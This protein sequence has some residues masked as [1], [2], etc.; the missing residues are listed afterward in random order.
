MRVGKLSFY[1]FPQ[2]YY[3][4]ATFTSTRQSRRL[5]GTCQRTKINS[6]YDVSDVFWIRFITI[7][8]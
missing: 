3:E 7:D 8:V 6:Q 5:Y 2:S 4:Y 1:D